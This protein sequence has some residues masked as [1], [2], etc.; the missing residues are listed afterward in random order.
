MSGSFWGGKILL[1]SW[2]LFVF[3]CPHKKLD[4]DLARED[5]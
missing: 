2:F 5:F 3:I 4:V 1:S